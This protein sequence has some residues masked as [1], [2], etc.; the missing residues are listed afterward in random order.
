MKQRCLT[1]MVGIW[2][3]GICSGFANGVTRPQLTCQPMT[4]AQ[5]E[6]SKSQWT[7]RELVGFASWCASCQSKI[8]LVQKDPQKYV[9]FAVFDEIPAVEATLAR[10]NVTAPCIT[11]EALQQHFAIRE[12]PWSKS[13]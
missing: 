9:V 6:K 10:L 11:G 13:L 4:I 1:W 12:L 8:S 5:F 2:A 7:G 3:L